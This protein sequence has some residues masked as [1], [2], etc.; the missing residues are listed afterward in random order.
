MQGGDAAGVHDARQLAELL[1]DPEAHVRRPAHDGR[2]GVARAECGERVLGG[3][4]GEE[5]VIVAGEE[6]GIVG[7][8]AEQRGGLGSTFRVRISG[9]AGAA[10]QR[11]VRDRAIAGAAA[12]VAGEPVVHGSPVRTLPPAW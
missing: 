4:R 12:E 1:G 7:D 3:R 5:S 11:S 10:G 2:I 9:L 6:I 8:R